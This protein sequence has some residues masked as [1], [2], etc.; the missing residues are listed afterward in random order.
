M[1]TGEPD[2]PVVGDPR[3]AVTKATSSSVLPPSQ[4]ELG[5]RLAGLTLTQQVMVLAIW[6]FL[7]AMMGFFVGFVD[8]ALAGRLSVEATNAIGVATYVGWLIG[9]VQSCVGI[10]ATALISRATG[11]RKRGL[12]SATVGQAM[13][14]AVLVGLGIGAAVFLF[15]PFIASFTGLTGASYDHCVLYLRI[16][17][18]A[19][20]FSA[21]LYVGGACLRGAGDTKTPFIVLVA[22]N[23]VNT[24]LSI[25]LVAGPEP[26][27]GRGVAGIAMGT[28]AAW[29]VGA[30]LIVTVLVHGWGLVQLKRRWLKPK[31]HLLM[32]ML[33]VGVPSLLE[34]F[35]AMWL[36]NFFIL[37]IVGQLNDPA[38]WGAHVVAIRLEAVSFLPG[39]AMG[40]AAATLAGQYLGLGDP[41]RARLAMIK[42]WQIGAAV[43]TGLGLVF[44]LFAEG[45]VRLATDQPELLA[46]SPT[47]L[48]IAGFVQV[49]FGTAIVLGQGMRGAGDTRT[50]MWLTAFST[51]GVRLPLAYFFAIGMGW[52]LVGLWYGLCTELV[53]RGCLFA[54]RFWQGGWM[55]AK[56]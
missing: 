37:R 3:A 32:R 25:L 39:F 46:T 54:V 14:L 26:I 20:P 2:V 13:V 6:P 12:A 35:L 19:A 40:I 56:V 51:Y 53:F 15:S 7:E 23:L 22:V 50:T 33:R 24:I 38:A 11:A 28:F 29:V 4:R 45:L 1:V 16:I 5:G 18:A 44:V 10:G 43:M 41:Q 9:L 8:T 55:K 47:L 27:G 31:G 21:V 34:S 49:F 42:C 36:A 48:R 52:G 30:G 17:A